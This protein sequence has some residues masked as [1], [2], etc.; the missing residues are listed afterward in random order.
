MRFFLKFEIWNSPASLKIRM[1]FRTYNIRF[2]LTC[3]VQNFFLVIK[4]KNKTRL[5]LLAMNLDIIIQIILYSKLMKHIQR[6]F[7]METN[8]FFLRKIIEKIKNIF[9]RIILHVDFKKDF[10]LKHMFL[11]LSLSFHMELKWKNIDLQCRID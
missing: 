10:K 2:H 1:I 9:L 6:N 8:T 4:Q 3:K 11:K 5:Q 7:V